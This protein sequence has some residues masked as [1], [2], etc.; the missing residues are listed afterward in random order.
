[1]L[2]QR[3]NPGVKP[4]FWDEASAHLMKRDRILKK[5]IPRHTSDW[6][7]PPRAPF[8][9]LARAVIGQ[10]VSVKSADATWQRFLS[11]CG[12]EPT[13]AAVL[14]VSAEDLREA[15]LSKRKA[16]YV[17]DLATH[18]LEE[19]VR[20]ALWADKDDEAIV[21]ELCAI[22]G[23]GR[24]TAQMFLIFSLQRPDVLP[25]DDIGLI[26]AISLHYFS[27]EPV[28]RFEAREVAQAWAPWRTVA[29]WYL[30]RSLDASA[31]R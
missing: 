14:Q 23:V 19:R 12:G 29:T 3:V 7:L 18:F 24:W 5:L 28:S 22:R 1:M 30:W 26:K 4:D 31:L 9:S 27:G 21:A 16:E 2:D 13:P 20:P 15:G 6:M 10:Q 25:L 17:H 11:K 8:I